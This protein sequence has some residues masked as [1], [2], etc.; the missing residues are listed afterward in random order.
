MD[1]N[2]LGE[3]NTKLYQKAAIIISLLT[4]ILFIIL[5]IFNYVGYEMVVYPLLVFGLINLLYYKLFKIQYDK[6]YFYLDSIYKK[7]KIS[8]KEFVKIKDIF[9]LPAIYK[10]KFKSNSYMFMVDD[11]TLFKDFF[12]ISKKRADEKLTDKINETIKT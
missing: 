1:M 3:Q 5:W 12:S 7:K 10:I 11:S 6:D 2:N 4:M 8:I 9:Y